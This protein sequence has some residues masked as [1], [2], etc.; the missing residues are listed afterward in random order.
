MFAY[1]DSVPVPTDQPFVMQIVGSTTGGATAR[2]G[3]RDGDRIDLR[4]VNVYA[5]VAMLFQPVTIKPVMLVVRRQGRSFTAQF[6]GST[7]YQGNVAV[8]LP[9]YVFE[10]LAYFLALGCACVIAARRWQA[11][12]VVICASPSLLSLVGASGQ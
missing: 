7:I 1:W 5:R 8:K 3:I 6:S 11:R 4:G 12:K 2:A 9:S 10:F